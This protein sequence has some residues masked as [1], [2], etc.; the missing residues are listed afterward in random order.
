MHT[1][2][3]FDSTPLTVYRLQYSMYNK[4]T[5]IQ[6]CIMY[7]DIRGTVDAETNNAMMYL[8]THPQA[9]NHDLENFE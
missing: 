4:N 1:A 6:K 5:F 8:L 3:G 7:M 2:I 9:S